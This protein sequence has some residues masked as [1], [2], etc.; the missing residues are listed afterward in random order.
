M[1]RLGLGLVLALA[2]ATA[3]SGA[4]PTTVQSLSPAGVPV[5]T[6]STF[7]HALTYVVV[8]QSVQGE[9]PH[10]SKSFV[11]L[12]GVGID[13]TYHVHTPR[14][15]LIRLHRAGQYTIRSYQQPCQSTCR[16]LGPETD[17]CTSTFNAA[18]RV[19]RF[20]VVVTPGSGC[21][22]API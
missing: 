1:A 20:Q 22:I 17:A 8:H 15:R 3:C 10:G 9:Y 4:S 16:R 18:G 7:P 13:R 2:T 11:R 21:T 14:I 12:V 19:V 5:P 6:R